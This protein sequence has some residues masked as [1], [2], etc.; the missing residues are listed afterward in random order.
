MNKVKLF[1]FP[2]AGGSA[3]IFNKWKPYID[4]RIELVPVELTGRG[5]RM[6]E[7][8]YKDVPEAI[9]DVFK[10]IKKDIRHTPY[11]LFGHSMGGMIAYELA[12]KIRDNRLPEPLHIFFSGRNAPHIKKVEEKKFHLMNDEEFK[13]EIIKLGGT[14]A[15]LFE[16]A[17]LM[18]FFLPL[19]KSDFKM[20]ETDLHLTS[21][22]KP[23]ST[24]I[25]IL[26]G[27][28]DDL[29]TEECDGWR[30]HTSKH[31]N[32]HYFNG[33]HFFLHN[34]IEQ[35]LKLINRTLLEHIHKHRVEQ[36]ISNR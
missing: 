5:I 20:A 27:K 26:L 8:L 21:G 2:Y 3:V 1:C 11:A 18:T 17:E 25:S 19:L 12:Q 16:H 15:E 33:G 13:R 10:I 24:D 34:E 31:C 28:D 4:S 32:I 35:L 36:N 14:P 9:D 7:P 23:L 30:Q 6:S 29:I 22:V